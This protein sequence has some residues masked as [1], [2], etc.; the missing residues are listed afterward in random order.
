MFLNKFRNI[1]VSATNVPWGHKRGNIY[2]GN[3]VYAT[4]FPRLRVPLDQTCFNR[5]ATHFNISMF[6]DKTMFDGV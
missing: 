5:L 2:F 6:G 1:F 4:S 3:N